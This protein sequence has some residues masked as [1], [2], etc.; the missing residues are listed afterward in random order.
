MTPKFYAVKELERTFC[1]TTLDLS[2]PRNSP[3]SLEYPFNRT[4]IGVK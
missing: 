1:N 3:E 4:I 2:K